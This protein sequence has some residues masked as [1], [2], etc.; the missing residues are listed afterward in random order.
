MSGY[1]TEHGVVEVGRYQVG[2]MTWV[3]ARG[4]AH[5][6]QRTRLVLVYF[7]LLPPVMWVS[8]YGL[9]IACH[10]VTGRGGPHS[11]ALMGW[12]GV[13]VLGLVLV[14]SWRDIARIFTRDA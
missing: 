1:A 8:L 2:G 3:R 11:A 9:A 6:K 12:G 7:L 14:S 5:M 10:W 13:A 4:R